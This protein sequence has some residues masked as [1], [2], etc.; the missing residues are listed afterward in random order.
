MV[1][2]I[3]ASV[4]SVLFLLQMAR[5]KKYDYMV[6]NLEGNSYALK[7]IYCVGF[8]WNDTKIL[9]IPSSIYEKMIGHARMLY[10]PKFAEYYVTL[11]W[12]QGLSYGHFALL[13][14]F[15]VS[16]I[17]N[18]GLGAFMG[19]VAAGAAV[20]SYYNDMEDDIKKRA[21]E[22]NIE[23]PE[24]VSSMALLVNS[25]MVL[26]EAWEKVA[27]SKEGEIYTLMQRA[28]AD[29]RNGL[30]ESDAIYRFG[31]LTNSAEIKKFT[32]SVVQGLEKGSS[33]LGNLLVNQSSE[34]W[35]VKRQYMLQKGE[36][37]ASKLLAPVMI[38]FVGI[39]ILVLT[40]AIGMFSA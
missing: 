17:M 3:I 30:S 7:S 12:A 39:I 20:Y 32:S 33:E 22:C 9:H 19:V 38:I 35:N 4:L 18:S 24:V 11:H 25:G 37:A 8:A 36:A 21:T 14:G 29:M 31:I 5:G 2:L 23:L 16:G 27:F 15:L 40:G 28:C 13:V 34:L 6:E 10:D 26:K 1:Y